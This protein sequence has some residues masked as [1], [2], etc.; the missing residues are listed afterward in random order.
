[1]T[2]SLIFWLLAPVAVMFAGVSKA[3]F[4]SGAAFASA[5]VLAVILPPAQALGLMLPLLMLID[6]ATLRPYWRKW[7]WPDAR[8]LILG[9]LPGVA[10]GVV[11]FRVANDDVLRLLIGAVSLGFVIWQ[12]WPRTV[13]RQKMPVWAGLLAGAVAGFTSFVSHAG[14]PPAAVYL[15]SRGIGKTAYQ[16]TTVLVFWAINI[17]KFVPYAFLG[18]FTFET[19]RA[20]AILA[21]FAL[22]GA[23]VGVKLHHAVSERVFFALTYALLT[24]TGVKLVFDALF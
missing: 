17:A 14:G 19:L 6:L 8:V 20:G 24:I 11:L 18:V 1:M 22:L 5:V 9:G 12:V 13:A 21:P 16:A 7:S 23:W 2:D 10:G 15:L 4:G 3:G